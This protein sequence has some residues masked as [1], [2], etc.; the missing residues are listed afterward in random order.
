MN[1]ELAKKI[2]MAADKMDAGEKTLFCGTAKEMRALA[3]K[4]RTFDNANDSEKIAMQNFIDNGDKITFSQ[5]LIN[6]NYWS[7]AFRIFIA[8]QIKHLD[9]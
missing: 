9:H 6:N 1:D 5:I 4:I 7:P 3:E 8:Y 2:E